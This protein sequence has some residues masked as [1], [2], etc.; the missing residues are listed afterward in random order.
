M[1][2]F[3]PT[4]EGAVD[5]EAVPADFTTRMAL[6]IKSGLLVPGSRRRANYAVREESPDAISFAA[7][8]FWTAYAIGLNDVELRRAASNRI[9]Y[10]GS[11][12]RWAT[13]A[14]IH[15]FLLTGLVLVVILALPSAR[16]QVAQT[17]WGWPFLIA[18]LAFF[19]LAWPWLLVEIH[20]RVVPR[21]LERIVREVAAA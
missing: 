8:G 6:R 4:Y 12:R 9:D 11:F 21:S 19:G 16:E 2:L 5:L 13:Y 17:A 10:H 15:S 3:S 1:G 14:V 20:R 7:V 18:L